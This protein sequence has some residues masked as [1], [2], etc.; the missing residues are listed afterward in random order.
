MWGN[1]VSGLITLHCMVY[2]QITNKVSNNCKDVYMHHILYLISNELNI[3][4]S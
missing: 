3:L 4:L 2:S 1:W